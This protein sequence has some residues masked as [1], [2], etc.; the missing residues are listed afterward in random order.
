[1]RYTDD[2]AYRMYAFLKS[3]EGGALADDHIKVL[4]DEEATREAILDN[5]KILFNKAKSNDL[6]LLYFS[7]HGLKGSFLPIDYDGY[8]NKLNHDEINAVLQSCQAKYKLCIADACHSGSLL[9]MK[10]ASAENTL[11]TYYE[12]LANAKSGTALIMSS[13]SEE[14]SLEASG[15]RQGVFSHFLIRGLKGEADENNDM[16]VS[17]KE[18]FEFVETQVGSYTGRRQTPVLKG[19]YDPNMTVSVRRK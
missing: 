16:V 10:G 17:V 4:I 5:M 15:L 9:A 12:S 1:L 19:D 13:K 8:E 3:P 18:L 2:D 6:V 11:K 7:G 14:S